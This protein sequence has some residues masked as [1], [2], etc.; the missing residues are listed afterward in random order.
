MADRILKVSI[1]GDASS[2]KTL[3]PDLS[4]RMM[5]APDVSTEF[6]T[7]RIVLVDAATA[8][9]SSTEIR[10]RVANRQPIS[11]LVPELVA[12][13]IDHHELYGQN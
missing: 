11:G 10:R 13:H 7:P 6:L 8:P 3:L 4:G 12:R 2:L 9:V 5:G 1:L